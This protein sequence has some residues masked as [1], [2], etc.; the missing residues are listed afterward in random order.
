MNKRQ[1]IRLDALVRIPSFLDHHTLELGDV[2]RSPARVALDAV[3]R[4]VNAGVEAQATAAAD[5]RCCAIRRREL[6]RE[7]YTRY[8]RPIVVIA[9]A[10]LHCNPRAATLRCPS[11]SLG[12]EAFL[13][14][15]ETIAELAVTYLHVFLRHR[16]PCDLVARVRGA[17]DA[18]DRVN[19]ES[20]ACTKR[21]MAATATVAAALRR[22][23]RLV[24]V[25]DALV[26]S[27]GG[28]NAGLRAEWDAERRRHACCVRFDERLAGVA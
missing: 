1:H 3:I 24:S 8:L 4:D 13:A 28:R 6:R 9:R 12:D 14:E 2:N 10:E 15:A 19:N 21:Q 11:Q 20:I 25:L 23:V 17:I 22:A 18:I 7:L 27:R 16:L 5:F 26:K